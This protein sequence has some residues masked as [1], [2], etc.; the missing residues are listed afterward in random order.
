MILKIINKVCGY[1]S[2]MLIL[3]AAIVIM[4]DVVCRYF[5]NSPS[6]Y[7]PYIAAFLILGA[8]FIG[9]AWALQAGGHVFVELVTDKLKPLQRKVCFTIGYSFAMVFVG[10]LTRA[11]WNFSL[12]AAEAGWRAQGNLP[13]P[14]VIL[15]GVMTFGAALLFVSLFAKIVETWRAK[16]VQ[17][18][19]AQEEAA[20]DNATQGAAAQDNAAQ[21]AAAQEDAAQE[22]GVDAIG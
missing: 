10:A 13:I 11:C 12:T 20:Q 15:Y 21:G 1:I 8:V 14:S 16:P 18:G 19:D 5:F 2:G 3:I 6:L 17:E 4:Y 22:N 7:A 9:T